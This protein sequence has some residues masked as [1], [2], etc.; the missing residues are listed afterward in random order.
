M[1]DFAGYNLIFGYPWLV[2]ADFKI[3]FKTEIFKWW[4][5]QELKECILLISLKDILDNVALDKIIYT[6]YLKEY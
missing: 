6:L 2:K 5:N 3:Y 1:A 4:N